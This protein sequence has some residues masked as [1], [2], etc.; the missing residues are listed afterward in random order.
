MA[1]RRKHGPAHFAALIAVAALTGCT[2]PRVHVLHDPLQPA[3]H[4]DLG[5]SYERQGEF[6]A[7]LREYRKAAV[8]PLKGR[9]LVYQGNVHVR[10]GA[11]DEA[12]RLYRAA[13]R[14]ESH[15]VEALNNLAWLLAQEGRRLD[16]AERLV[17]RALAQDPEPRGPYEDTLRAVL[18]ARGAR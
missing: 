11:T 8:G 5:V 14:A 9:A 15:N 6:D 3:E 1:T 16:E 2:L 7:A 18:E 12:E 13:L 17:R 10:H 4:L